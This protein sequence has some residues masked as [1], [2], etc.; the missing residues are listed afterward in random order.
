MTNQT[1]KSRYHER[2]SDFKRPEPI[3]DISSQ[4]KV[5]GCL[6][7]YKSFHSK[8]HHNR[9]C[10]PCKELASWND[11]SITYSIIFEKN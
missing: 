6:K 3:L 5:R 2:S 10:I 4:I 7:C 11:E 9:I 8:G 1:R